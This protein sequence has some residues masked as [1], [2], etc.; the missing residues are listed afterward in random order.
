[1]PTYSKDKRGL[2]IPILVVQLLFMIAK[3]DYDQTIDRFEAI[4][5]Y[6]SRYLKK[7]DN[8]RSNCFINMLLQIPSASFHKAGV[9]RKAKKYWDRLQSTPLEF[10]KQSQEIEIM[11]Y[12]DLW[13]LILESLEPKF[14]R[15]RK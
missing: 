2:N 12:E 1:M 7:D 14:Y 5:K 15:L 4:K 10:A 6:C 3:K 8:L 9:E 13:E 11:P